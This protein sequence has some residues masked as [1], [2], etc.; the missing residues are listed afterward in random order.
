MHWLSANRVDLAT[1]VSVLL[2]AA[3][4]I[5]GNAIVGTWAWAL[6]AT[7]VVLI[8]CL[9]G[10]EIVRRRAEQQPAAEAPPAP[11]GPWP[12]PGINVSDNQIRVAGGHIYDVHIGGGAFAGII[13]VFALAVALSGTVVTIGR[14]QVVAD[15]A[16][17]T[18]ES[19]TVP[20]TVPRRTSQPYQHSRALDAVPADLDP[21]QSTRGQP[22]VAYRGGQQALLFVNGAQGAVVPT[23]SLS[24]S[25]CR[26]A[27]GWASTVPLS[28]GASA[29][30]CLRTSD[31][32]YG[33][34][35]PLFVSLALGGIATI[36][37]AV[38]YL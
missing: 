34:I 35:N 10:L 4:G 26:T 5:V 3:V 19:P 14:Q 23:G 24:E 7:L 8:V 29:P 12:P 22:D 9:T 37:Y 32:H 6:I 25:G 28:P 36:S 13:A 2:S 31:G 20:P 18:P 30:L 21:P 17:T 16:T 27:T 33:T 15:K 1:A 11:A 38:W